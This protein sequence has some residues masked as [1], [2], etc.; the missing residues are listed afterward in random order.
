MRH[1]E[2]T[3]DKILRNQKCII[4]A[5][6]RAER[7][8]R[9][10]GL[11]SNFYIPDNAFGNCSEI[12]ESW[13]DF[14]V[15]IPS[16]SVVFSSASSLSNILGYHLWMD[17]EDVS[18][19]DLGTVLNPFLGFSLTVRDFQ[20]ASLYRDN[21]LSTKLRYFKFKIQRYSKLKW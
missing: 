15:D 17:R 7:V 19:Y 1:V 9:K 12:I 14:I 10:K 21:R 11:E 8:L 3:I 6:F 13:R 4:V 16:G 5:N 20:S 18:F 2:R